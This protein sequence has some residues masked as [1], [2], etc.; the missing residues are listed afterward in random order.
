MRKAIFLLFL[1][2]LG[3]SGVRSYDYLPGGDPGVEYFW[4]TRREAQLRSQL[5]YLQSQIE[6]QG[7]ADYDRRV[8]QDIY[9]RIDSVNTEKYWAPYN[10]DW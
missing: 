10:V 7:S 1:L 2:L 5:G 6:Q 8:L 9:R 3:C 4:Q